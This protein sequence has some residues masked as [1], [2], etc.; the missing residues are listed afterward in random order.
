VV[1]VLRRLAQAADARFRSGLA[2]GTGATCCSAGND[3]SVCV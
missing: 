2:T 3:T 1:Q